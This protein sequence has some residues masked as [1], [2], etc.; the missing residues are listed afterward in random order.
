MRLP[1]NSRTQAIAQGIAGKLELRRIAENGPV[2]FRA[3]P[4]DGWTRSD[5]KSLANAP[6]GNGV[7]RRI[8]KIAAL[9]H[10][11]ERGVDSPVQP[12][13][14]WCVNSQTEG[15]REVREGIHKINLRNGLEI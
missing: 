8:Q 15:Q 7:S 2:E 4:I 12:Q 13:T 11:L 1:Q 3:G 14:V 10:V 6:G 5:G 9:G